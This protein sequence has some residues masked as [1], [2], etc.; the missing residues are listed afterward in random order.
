MLYFYSIFCVWWLI[1]SAM[2]WYCIC[3]MWVHF[4]L[5]GVISQNSLANSY[6]RV[7]VIN[8]VAAVVKSFD[9]NNLHFCVVYS[10]C[11]QCVCVCVKAFHVL[12][13]GYILENIVDKYLQ[14]FY[15]KSITEVQC[16]IFLPNSILSSAVESV[17]VNK[18]VIKMSLQQWMWTQTQS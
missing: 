16:S 18:H 3:Y 2:F 11:I 15:S 1:S 4:S 9:P 8:R 6:S 12:L 10:L 5:L 14:D 13:L 17:A 7:S